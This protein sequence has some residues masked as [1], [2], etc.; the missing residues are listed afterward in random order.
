MFKR[1]LEVMITFSMMKNPKLDTLKKEKKNLTNTA[2]EQEDTHWEVKQTFLPS[3]NKLA[4]L[5]SVS[6]HH[7]S[8]SFTQRPSKLSLLH[9]TAVLRKNST[10]KGLFFFLFKSKAYPIHSSQ[11]CKCVKD[12]GF[13][14][15]WYLH[16]LIYYS[17][18]KI[19][20]SSVL[21]K[22]CWR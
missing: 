6:Q 21:K 22:N 5:R 3:D 10:S 16:Y 19:T 18:N 12:H 15:H 1:D 7:F 2:L 20:K 11:S 14:K 9:H 4:W 13:G 8:H 17:I